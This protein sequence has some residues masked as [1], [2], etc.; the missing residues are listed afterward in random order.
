MLDIT[1]LNKETFVVKT[2]IGIFHI[3]QPKV[4][5][6]N[7]LISIVKKVNK[8]KNNIE[9]ET[10]EELFDI[11]KVIINKNKEKRKISMSQI[12]ENFDISD[13]ILIL[14]ELFT[15]IGEVKNEKNS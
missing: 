8:D 15:W 12:D 3:Y 1:V 9:A 11:F 10:V 7:K 6:V 13:I 5:V 2:Y 14:N 4:K